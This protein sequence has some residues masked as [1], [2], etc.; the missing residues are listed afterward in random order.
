[1][2]IQ[3]CKN[4]GTRFQYK[5]LL[6]DPGGWNDP[7]HCNKCGASHYLIRTSN[8]IVALLVLLPMFLKDGIESL[9]PN[10]PLALLVYLVYAGIIKI[11]SP[12][13]LKY[14]LKDKDEDEK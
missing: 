14:K 2:G 8:F 4:C 6:K 3:K 9:G 1:M 12:Y 7:I 13:I 5:H 11:L 10:F